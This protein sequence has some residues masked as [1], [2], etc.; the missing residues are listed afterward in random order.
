[1]FVMALSE[2]DQR[3]YEDETVNRMHESLDLFSQML[4]SPF[5]A[6]TSFIIFFNKQVMNHQWPYRDSITR[7]II[8]GVCMIFLSSGPQVHTV[9]N[10]FR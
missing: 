2:Y 8:S 10:F 6:T 4:T 9:E 7:F 1:M 3:L 5:F